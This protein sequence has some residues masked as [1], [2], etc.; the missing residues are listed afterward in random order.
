MKLIQRLVTYLSLFFAFVSCL[1]ILLINPSLAYT[2]DSEVKITSKIPPYPSLP[3]TYPMAT[4]TQSDDIAQETQ[5]DDTVEDI[6]INPIAKEGAEYFR[7]FAWETFI[8]LN[9]PAD[10]KTGEAFPEDEIKIGQKPDQPRVWEFYSYPKEVFSSNRQTDMK[11]GKFNSQ[12]SPPQCQGQNSDNATLLESMAKLPKLTLSTGISKDGTEIGTPR[13]AMPLVDRKGN[14]I[15]SEERINPIEVHQIV[16]NGWYD[17]KNITTFNDQKKSF[18]LVCSQ[19]KPGYNTSVSNKYCNNNDDYDKEGAIEI[20]PAWMV[21]KDMNEK[22]RKKYYIT[23][24]AIK[25]E[26]KNG[27]KDKIVDVALV[28]FHI[29]QKTSYA[30]WVISTFEHIK[31]APD[32]KDIE[33]KENINE[34]YHLY[35]PNCK[36]E[37]CPK[38]NSL[39]AKKPYLWGLKETDQSLDKESNNIYNV[40]D[41]VY[42]MTRNEPQ[43]PSQITREDPLS[44]EEKLSN[45]KWTESDEWGEEKV[46]PQYYQLIGVQWLVDPRIAFSYSF[47]LHGKKH[48]ANVALEP[49]NQ[50]S[51][52]CFECHAKYA[53]LP[54]SDVPADLSFLMRRTKKSSIIK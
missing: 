16:T 6:P 9:W 3:Y 32:N 53:K 39:T 21:A 34:N 15:M 38:N 43:I 27:K 33:R 24:R 20:K 12:Y 36:G 4:E 42:A 37:T 48:L 44:V 14:Y 50:K 8:A 22:E 47:N 51:S 28:G 54:G 26:T 49:F 29:F 41:T 52:S 19:K 30:G 17:A 40:T 45:K 46:W 31:N 13:L 18:Q 2:Y 25:V 11:D 23:K 1:W 7:D 5:S 35:D 10:C